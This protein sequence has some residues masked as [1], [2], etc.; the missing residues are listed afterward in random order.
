MH[1]IAFRVHRVILPFDLEKR[2]G[3][4]VQDLEPPPL[5]PAVGDGRQEAELPSWA[6]RLGLDGERRGQPVHGDILAVTLDDTTQ[7]LSAPVRVSLGIP[8]RPVGSPTC[9]RYS[10][11]GIHL[12]TVSGSGSE[13][14][15]VKSTAVGTSR[16]LLPL[17]GRAWVAYFS[18]LQLRRP[19]VKRGQ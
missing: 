6:A 19:A 5:S 13:E 12:H 9:L 17:P 10:P 11:E 4:T 8:V 14:D 15:P 7:S 16:S 2:V 18:P 1:G 3:E